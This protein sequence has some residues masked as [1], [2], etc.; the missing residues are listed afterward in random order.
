MNDSDYFKEQ[1]KIAREIVSLLDKLQVEPAIALAAINNVASAMIGALPYKH[2][3]S[4]LK[5]FIVSMK[6]NINAIQKLN[7]W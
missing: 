6:K 3:K 4:V 7:L 2:S 1:H 5:T